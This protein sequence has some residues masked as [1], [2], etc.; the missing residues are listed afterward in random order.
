MTLD[1]VKTYFGSSYRFSKETGF[2]HNNFINW[3]KKGYIPFLTQ[4][5]IEEMTNGNLKA[6]YAHGEGFKYV[7]S[8]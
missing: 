5:K 1:E 3:R 7:K 6:D 2:A 4:G 8:D